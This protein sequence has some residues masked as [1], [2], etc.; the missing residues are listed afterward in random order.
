VAVAP[1]TTPVPDDPPRTFRESEYD[2]DAPGS[3]GTD[4][5]D[6]G[7]GPRSTDE[8]GLGDEGDFDG[9]REAR[10]PNGEESAIP[11]KKSA[12][13]PAPAVGDEPTVSPLDLDDEFVWTDAPR[14]TRVKVRARFGSPT[15]ARTR[16]SPEEA[17]ETLP[18]STKVAQKK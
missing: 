2:D 3:P 12:P 5:S 7:F 16:V 18:V 15:L 4:E 14:R 13:T 10:R 8:Q 11:M 6:D 17:W 1:S 9:A